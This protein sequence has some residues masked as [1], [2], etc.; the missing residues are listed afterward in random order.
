MEHHDCEMLGHGRILR[1]TYQVYEQLHS[2][3]YYAYLQVGN[4]VVDRV[5]RYRDDDDTDRSDTTFDS[6][7]GIRCKQFYE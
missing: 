2:P 3:I 7:Y 4:N 5:Q 1:S 6:S